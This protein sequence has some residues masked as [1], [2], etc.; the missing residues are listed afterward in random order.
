MVGADPPKVAVEP[1]PADVPP[2]GDEVVVPVPNA[3]LF[4]WLKSPP[5]VFVAPKGEEVLLF[6]DPNPPNPLVVAAEVPPKIPLPAEA[7]PKPEAGF[8]PNPP[9]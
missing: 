7:V 2:N 9:D 8:A 1:N 6:E 3:G 4:A 5:P